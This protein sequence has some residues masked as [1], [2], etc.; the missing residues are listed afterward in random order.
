MDF[1]GK[2]LELRSTPGAIITLKERAGAA[3]FGLSAAQINE[4]AA[5]YRVLE[6]S[7]LNLTEAVAFSLRHARP[8]C[9]EKQL[10]A[11]IEY[12]CRGKRSAGR[13]EK[14]IRGLE[15]SL[16]RFAADFKNGAVHKVTRNEIEDWLDEED[17]SLTT[18][19]SYRVPLKSLHNSAGRFEIFRGLHERVKAHADAIPKFVGSFGDE[20]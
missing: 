11:A 12:L 17:F 15:W 13:N 10:N 6:G 3:A 19:G 2:A 20:V 16:G 1:G 9:G 5:A 8:S 18:R 7:G 14:Y 4:A